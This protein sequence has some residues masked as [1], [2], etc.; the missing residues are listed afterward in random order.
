[1]G[2]KMAKFKPGDKVI[3]THDK[4]AWGIIKEGEVYTV[5]SYNPDFPG[6]LYL[7]E[8]PCGGFEE[9]HFKLTVKEKGHD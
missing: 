7:E 3:C 8:P 5:K 2:K 6:V 4:N 9:C 1:M